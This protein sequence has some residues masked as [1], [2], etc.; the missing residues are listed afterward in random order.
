MKVVLNKI[1]QTIDDNPEPRTSSM[2][3]DIRKTYDKGKL[4][5]VNNNVDLYLEIS[6]EDAESVL[7]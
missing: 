7:E 1:C 6:Y 5:V 2:D 3:C 4:H